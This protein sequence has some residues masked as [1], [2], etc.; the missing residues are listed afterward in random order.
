MYLFW[1]LLKILVWMTT[2]AGSP[3]AMGP[4]KACWEEIKW[5]ETMRRCPPYK[6]F[7]I[8]CLCRPLTI[9][10]SSWTQPSASGWYSALEGL[11]LTW[12]TDAVPGIVMDWIK[13]GYRRYLQGLRDGLEHEWVSFSAD[14]EMVQLSRWRYS[15]D[16]T[17][18]A[19]H[20]WILGLTLV[21]EL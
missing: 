2:T 3:C 10:L 12:L 7:R 6:T 8:A 21:H 14:R 1:I 18:P 19:H 16:Y 11:A 13:P 9:L 5:E 4:M 20:P 15:T 17:C